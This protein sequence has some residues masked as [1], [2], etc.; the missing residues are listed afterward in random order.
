M[1][2]GKGSAKQQELVEIEILSFG[3][4]LTPNQYSLLVVILVVLK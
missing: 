4:I 2:V 1:E 3:N